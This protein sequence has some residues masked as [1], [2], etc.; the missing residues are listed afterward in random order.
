MAAK[1]PKKIIK[2]TSD[3]FDEEVQ[4]IMNDEGVDREDAWRIAKNREE[5][6]SIDTVRREEEQKLIKKRSKTK[7]NE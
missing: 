3:N 7:N 2:E 1:K 5:K 4:R 6:K